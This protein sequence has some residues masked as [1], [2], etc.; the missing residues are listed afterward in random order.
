[1]NTFHVRKT[2]D[3]ILLHLGKGDD[4]LQCLNQAITIRT[5]VSRNGMLWFQAGGGIV[6]K[7]N[8]EYELQEV[9]NK[10]GALKK[11]ITMAE[12]SL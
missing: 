2:G 12:N 7:S 3:V 1:M 4:M 10:L 9:N 8:A 6:A 5:F 11:A